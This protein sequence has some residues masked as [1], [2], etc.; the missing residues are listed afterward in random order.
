MTL[1][2]FLVGSDAASLLAT[3]C[4]R[5]SKQPSLPSRILEQIRSALWNSAIADVLYIR[6]RWSSGIG[7]R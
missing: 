7:L 6:V 4:S 5:K 3:Q 1:S 2:V